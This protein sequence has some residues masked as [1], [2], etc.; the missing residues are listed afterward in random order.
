MPCRSKND[1]RRSRRSVTGR[2]DLAGTEL[3]SQLG[4]GD[5]GHLYIEK[6]KIYLVRLQK[7]NGLPRV[8]ERTQYSHI[9]NFPAKAFQ[10][11]DG[12]VFIIYDDTFQY[13]GILIHT[14]NTSEVCMIRRS[15]FDLPA[16]NISSRLRILGNPIPPAAGIFL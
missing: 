15:S 14:S 8:L 11:P 12:Q 10:H 4:A 9:G 16:A 1:L 2:N 6:N 7:G 3:H 5:M 13:P